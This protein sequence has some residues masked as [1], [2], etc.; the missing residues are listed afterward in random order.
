MEKFKGVAVFIGLGALRFKPLLSHHNI[1]YSGVQSQTPTCV[2]LWER[3]CVLHS[4]CCCTSAI[5]IY[6]FAVIKKQLL[7]PKFSTF[8]IR[9]SI[10]TVVV[11][12]TEICHCENLEKLFLFLYTDIMIYFISHFTPD[13]QYALP[14]RLIVSSFESALYE[15]Q[16]TLVMTGHNLSV[17]KALD[18]PM[19]P[20][21]VLCKV[22]HSHCAH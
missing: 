19:F 13:L 22:T 1:L 4:H 3:N 2:M 5:Q 14:F 15:Q 17:S 21:I 8:S 20:L 18:S 12:L 6:I 11:M 16:T 7:S 9:Q 10:L